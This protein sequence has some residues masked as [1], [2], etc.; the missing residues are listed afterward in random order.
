MGDYFTSV[1]AQV[2][3]CEILRHISERH[4]DKTMTDFIDVFNK[5]I[6]DDQ[7]AENASK[8][9][10]LQVTLHCVNHLMV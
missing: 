2:M 4:L 8:H 6:D 10:A 9:K 7:V 3:L 5:S 1:V